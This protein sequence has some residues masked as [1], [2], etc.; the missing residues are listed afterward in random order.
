M[1]G[2]DLQRMWQET[3]SAPPDQV[4]IVQDIFGGKK[5]R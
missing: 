5:K 4:K 2:E 3:L 1:R